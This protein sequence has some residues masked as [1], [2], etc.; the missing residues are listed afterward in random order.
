MIDPRVK[1][2]CEEFGVRIVPANVYPE[3]R[4]TRAVKTLSRILRRHGEAH[5]RMVM[6]TM[7]ETANN[8]ALM[9]E[10]GLWSCSDLVRAYADAIEADP[11]AWFAVWDETPVG[12]LQYSVQHRLSGFV[13]QRAALAGMIHERLY[14]RF[15]KDHQ[16]QPDL[17]EMARI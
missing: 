11:E 10:S 12:P 4:E 16:T 8:C 6:M 2:L 9:D 3:P 14:A 5:L 7:T 13:S 15:D 1:A 17:L